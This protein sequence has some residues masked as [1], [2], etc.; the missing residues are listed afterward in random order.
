MAKVSKVRPSSATSSSPRKGN[1]DTLYL[2]TEL[3]T[4]P[5]S[6]D[7]VFIMIYGRKNIGKSSLAAQFEN[8][9]TMMFEATRRNL[10]IFQVPKA[11]EPDLTWSRALKYQDMICNSDDFQRISIDTVDEAYQQCFIYVCK[12]AGV[13]HPDSASKPYE[14]WMEIKAQ[15]KEFVL[16]FR[17]AGKGVT[18]VSHEKVKPLITKAKGLKR[19]DSPENTVKCDRIEPSC[20]GQVLDV[21][22]QICDYV[23]YY[24]FKD[25]RRAI[26]VRSPSEIA[27]TACGMGETFCDPDGGLIESFEAGSD[28]PSSYEAIIR[29]FNNELYDMDYIPPPSNK[30]AA[31][32]KKTTPVKKKAVKKVARR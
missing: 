10:A 16:T 19:D 13:R 20:S 21:I 6:L 8:N 23:F 17:E 4:P 11:G 12:Q 22:T 32:G 1:D 3:N 29:A 24:H 28:A 27:W 25:A 7:D 18:F 15:F 5:T 30:I 2:P 9:L 14:L 31:L 26:M